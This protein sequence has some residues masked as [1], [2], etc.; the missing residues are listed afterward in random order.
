MAIDTAKLKLSTKSVVALL[1]TLGALMQDPAVSGLV[2][3]VTAHHSGLASIVG[4]I[5]AVYAVLHN[6]QVEAEF[7]IEAK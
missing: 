1:L 3:R 4:T 6:P 7:G 2:S 5:L